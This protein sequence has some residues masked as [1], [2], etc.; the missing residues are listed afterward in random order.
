MAFGV[1]ENF[2]IS[3]PLVLIAETLGRAIEEA[4]EYTVQ[5]ICVY[6]RYGNC[7]PVRVEGVNL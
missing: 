6:D 7:Y 1:Y 5:S 2:D 4:E 3:S